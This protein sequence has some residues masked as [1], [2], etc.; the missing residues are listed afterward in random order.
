[1]NYLYELDAYC[2]SLVARLSNGTIILA[3]NLDFYF[4][5]ET[6]KIMYI[7]H[8]YRG[9]LFIFESPMFAGMTAVFTGHKPH[10]FALSINERTRK[11][12]S[13]EFVD[14]L[15]LLLSGHD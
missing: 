9:D 11:E 8:F 2:T 10:A 1:M 12:S 3:R 13:L 4:P 15:A 14:N 6:R 7:A 5:N